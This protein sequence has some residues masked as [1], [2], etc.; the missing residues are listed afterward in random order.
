MH[1]GLSDSIITEVASGLKEGDTVITGITK[2]P[3]QYRNSIF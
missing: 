3:Y 1:L 2:P